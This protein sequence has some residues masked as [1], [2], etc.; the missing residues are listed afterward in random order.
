MTSPSVALPIAGRLTPSPLVRRAVVGVSLALLFAVGGLLA[1]GYIAQADR[2][3]IG[4]DWIG[5]RR[6]VERLV[7]TGSPYEPFQLAGPF[8]PEH[9]D[10]IHPPSALPLFAPFTLLPTPFDYL[11]WMGVPVVLTIVLLAR[12]AWWSW[13]IIAVL[14][15]SA[16]TLITYINGNSSMWLAAAFGWSLYLGWPAGLLALK[17]SLAPLLLPGFRKRPVAVVALAVAPIVLTLPFLHAWSD[18][19][20]V[21]RN[22]E[23][24]DPTYSLVQWPVFVIVALPWLTTRGAETVARWRTRR[25]A[26]ASR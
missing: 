18:F 16:N 4:L 17:P 15:V 10:F 8:R 3:P 7:S 21:L 5:Y 26:A 22:A 6:G 25:T 12:T 24:I 14:G 19:V 9:L 1:A 13:P 20:T 23:G 11:A 2:V